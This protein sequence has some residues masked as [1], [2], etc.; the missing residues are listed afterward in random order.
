MRVSIDGL[1]QLVP[2]GTGITTVLVSLLKQFGV[3]APDTHFRIYVSQEGF[4]ALDLPSAANIEYV[5]I[6][7]Q[8]SRYLRPMLELLVLPVLLQRDR[9]DLFFSPSNYYMPISSPV[10]S[11]LTVYDLSFKDRHA[12]YAAWKRFYYNIRMRS[13]LHVVDQIITISQASKDML[14]AHYNVQQEDVQII[15]PA[16]EECENWDDSYEMDAVKTKYRL[17]DQF[18]LSVGTHRRKRVGMIVQAL[19]IVRQ[20]PSFTEMPLVIVGPPGLL[21]VNRDF[22]EGIAEEKIKF[23]EF[24]PETDL[25]A[26]YALS[27]VYVS[28]SSHEGFGLTLLEAMNH[29]VPVVCSDIAAY[30][31]VAGNAALFFSQDSVESLADCILIALLN[32][33]VRQDLTHMGH[34]NLQRYSAA[35]AAAKYLE[36]FQE[37]AYKRADIY[38]A[39]TCC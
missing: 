6:S 31:E 26:L 3:Q 12:R 10:P 22:E 1:S 18:I 25:H 16:I 19:E 33:S 36:I 2:M 39:T 38:E 29:S 4:R 9:C 28:A 30:R 15:Y 23:L 21:E 14:V 35:V 32:Q 20:H 27:S 5:T 34:V 17:F 24:V 8:K 37:V 11:V 7:F 13:A